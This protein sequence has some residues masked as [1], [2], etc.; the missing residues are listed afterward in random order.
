MSIITMEAGNPHATAAKA[1]FSACMAMLVYNNALSKLLKE[2]L[3]IVLFWSGAFLLVISAVPVIEWSLQGTTWLLWDRKLSEGSITYWETLNK[4]QWEH[5]LYDTIGDLYLFLGLTGISYRLVDRSFPFLDQQ[6]G[7]PDDRLITIAAPFACLAIGVII[8]LKCYNR[9]SSNVGNVEQSQ[10]FLTLS[11]H[12]N[13]S[14]NKEHYLQLAETYYINKLWSLFL[15]AFHERYRDFLFRNKTQKRPEL[16]RERLST[17]TGTLNTIEHNFELIKRWKQEF[18]Q[19]KLQFVPALASIPVHSLYEELI[20]KLEII[21]YLSRVLKTRG[22][23]IRSEPGSKKIKQETLALCLWKKPD[24]NILIGDERSAFFECLEIAK[25]HVE[26]QT[27][28]KITGEISEH[29]VMATYS[30]MESLADNLEQLLIGL[31][32]YIEGITG[33]FSLYTFLKRKIRKR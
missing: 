19:K 23:S 22:P 32:S 15:N 10:Q 5:F 1:F 18:D 6:S 8:L 7:F 33:N 21:E 17:E 14:Q 30:T 25:K 27:G 24:W 16:I 11:A 20:T 26:A 12:C 2:D 31:E 28:K 13:P 29:W 4:P 9:V 3:Q